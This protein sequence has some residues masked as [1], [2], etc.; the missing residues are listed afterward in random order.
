M[1]II[2][3]G[4]H[5]SGTSAITRLIAL[6]GAH[7][8]APEELLPADADNPKG[9]WE[10][11]DVLACNRELLRLNGCV[12]HRTER[13]DD[14]HLAPTPPAL[15]AQMQAI[16]AELSAHTPCV[17]KDPR[18]CL[19]LPYWRALWPQPVV[20]VVHRAPGEIVQSLA[21]RN[22]MPS[23]KALAL[24]QHH[25]HCGLRALHGLPHCHA[26]HAALLSQPFATIE[27]LYHALVALGAGGLRLPSRH[28]VESFIDPALY[29]ARSES[30]LPLSAHQQALD[31]A[32]RGTI[33]G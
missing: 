20:V 10:R 1:Q 33:T 17:V 8:G 5:R 12:W 25:L 19:T 6:M 23:E 24:W 28:E 32:W 29:R 11:R 18:F 2:V 9:F 4:M 27:K 13:W 3:L 16:A 22:A 15:L 26:S 31:A 14:E 30:P 7:A 21:Q